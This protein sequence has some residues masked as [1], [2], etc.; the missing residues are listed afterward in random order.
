MDINQLISSVG[1]WPALVL[2]MGW[3]IDKIRREQIAQR[4]KRIDRLEAE[5]QKTVDA[6]NLELAE[7]KRIALEQSRSTRSTR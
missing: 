3:W 1:L 6:K 7:W 2:I 5:A 4:D